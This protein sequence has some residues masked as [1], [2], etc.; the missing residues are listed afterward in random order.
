MTNNFNEW[1]AEREDPWGYQDSPYELTK[2]QQ[3]IDLLP[4][5][6]FNK[7][8][9]IGCSEGCFTERL[10][11]L[12][13]SLTAIDISS[14]ALD[15]AKNRLSEYNHIDFVEADINN[16]D[17][18]SSQYDLIVCS[19]TLYYFGNK[20]TLADFVGNIASALTVGGYLLS[21]H[22]YLNKDDPTCPGYTWELPFGQRVIKSVIQAEG[23][24]GTV[25]DFTTSVY[26]IQLFQKSKEPVISTAELPLD[27]GLMEML[28]WGDS[29]TSVPI[30]MYH[31][32]MKESDGDD[33]EY[34]VSTA[35]FESHLQTLKEMGYKYVSLKDWCQAIK[36]KTPLNY[37]GVCLTFDDGFVNFK[38]EAWPLLKKYEFGATVF[39]VSSYVGHK[40]QWD[41]GQAG[42]T[43]KQLMGWEDI[44]ELKKNGVDFG[45]HTSQHVPLNQD[46]TITMLKKQIFDSKQLIDE[47][48]GDIDCIGYPYGSVNDDLVH[49]LLQVG[50]KCGVKIG[51]I[52]STIQD[53]CLAL[54]RFG[55][56]NTTGKELLDYIEPKQESISDTG[57]EI[58]SASGLNYVTDKLILGHSDNARDTKT[59]IKHGVTAMLNV[60]KDLDLESQPIIYYQKMGLDI[61]AF[62]ISTTLL[63]NVVGFVLE[64]LQVHPKV[65]IFCHSGVYRAP[66]VIGAV[67]SKQNNTSARDELD[68]IYSRFGITTEPE[69]YDGFVLKL[70]QWERQYR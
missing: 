7:V 21:A 15:R 9:E 6:R 23:K 17:I 67:L 3:Q 45:C 36:T 42:V 53:S 33:P 43:Q 50:F 57:S 56:W 64:L 24:L 66:A 49:Y 2:Y 8:L 48:I 32:I 61:N 44:I 13:D 26:G 38:D 69:S 70:Q 14:V 47:K 60:A 30:L 41:K 27:T 28:E 37:K 63:E 65:L 5:K 58:E 54:P 22:A 39:L 19:E 29:V 10:A 16:Y 35:N 46:M 1:Y 18:G 34:W 12:C 31:C 55:V 68:K 11:P 62:H 51:N 59:L 40:N 4:K 20:D 52:T 25:E